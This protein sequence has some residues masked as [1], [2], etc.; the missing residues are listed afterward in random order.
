MKMYAC[1][2]LYRVCLENSMAML[3]LK[4][5]SLKITLQI[6]GNQRLESWKP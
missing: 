5:V 4:M 1:E 3:H 2:F 6:L